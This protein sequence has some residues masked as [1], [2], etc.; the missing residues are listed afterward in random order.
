MKNMSLEIRS[1]RPVVMRRLDLLRDQFSGDL[2]CTGNYFAARL[3]PS[4]GNILDGVAT[5]GE[6]EPSTQLGFKKAAAC[7]APMCLFKSLTELPRGRKGGGVPLPV[8]EIV[9]AEN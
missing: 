9:P 3:R 8:I 6:I 2:D 1:V 7:R 4:G 5:V